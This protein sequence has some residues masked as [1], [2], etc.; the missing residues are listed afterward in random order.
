VLVFILGFTLFK[1]IN[2]VRGIGA[3]RGQVST[4]AA[5]IVEV[6]E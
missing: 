4:A 2:V 6:A 3:V 5:R 1:G